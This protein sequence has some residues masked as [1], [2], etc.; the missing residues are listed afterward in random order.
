MQKVYENADDHANNT[1]ELML[2]LNVLEDQIEADC[3]DVDPIFP[4]L[5]RCYKVFN[6][7]VSDVVIQLVNEVE[8]RINEANDHP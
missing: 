4:E 3:C 7:F 8:D 6:S 1:G 5:V 2:V